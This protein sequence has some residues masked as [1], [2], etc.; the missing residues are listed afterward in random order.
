MADKNV[1]DF[2]DFSSTPVPFAFLWPAPARSNPFDILVQDCIDEIVKISS[3]L[4]ISMWACTCKDFRSKLK[5]PESCLG[6]GVLARSIEDDRE[7]I[8]LRYVGLFGLF[9]HRELHKLFVSAGM[10]LS[11]PLWAGQ[12]TTLA[13]L[14]GNKISSTIGIQTG[15]INKNDVAHFEKYKVHIQS[16][17]DAMS[18]ALRVGAYNV[19]SYLKNVYNIFPH[20]FEAKGIENMILCIES[21][22][23][24]RG[25]IY[26]WCAKTNWDFNILSALRAHPVV[27]ETDIYNAFSYDYPSC[28]MNLKFAEELVK[29]APK[30][31]SSD[32]FLSLITRSD[33]IYSSPLS[34]YIKPMHILNNNNGRLPSN[35]SS[36]I[37]FKFGLRFIPN[38][39]DFNKIFFDFFSK[40]HF[41][42]KRDKIEK[43][44]LKLIRAFKPDEKYIKQ[45][46][47]YLNRIRLPVNYQGLDY[48][49]PLMPTL[50]SLMIGK[51]IVPKRYLKDISRVGVVPAP[52]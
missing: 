40:V 42:W 30:L 10:S 28:K 19:A 25:M 38:N 11:L 8:F 51:R 37:R 18:I 7:N 14:Q 24:L 52:N 39:D 27:T 3:P 50:A 45:Y 17:G 20:W 6:I 23:V 9:K 4:A 29:I 49:D 13:Y 31:L 16:M 48:N 47:E 43:T 36:W 12:V 5:F 35:I 1:L 15:I 22:G 32:A 33:G 2:L 34:E 26:T 44:T 41:W 46:V 21:A